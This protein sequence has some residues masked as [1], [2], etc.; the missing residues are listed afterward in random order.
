M[1][2]EIA[3][4]QVGEKTGS[5]ITI[6]VLGYA[7]VGFGRIELGEKQRGVPV[8]A[9]IRAGDEHLHPIVESGAI[10]GR[11][12]V[13]A[14]SSGCSGYLQRV[15]VAASLCD[16]VND[17]EQS[18][19]SIDAGTCATDDLNVIDKADI[20]GEFGSHGRGVIDVIV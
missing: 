13:S 2:I 4:D 10:R 5:A 19:R 11:S 3:I 8:A 14:K 15:Q 17:G 9:V 1:D 18:A 16:H 20:N 6:E 12:L 7:V